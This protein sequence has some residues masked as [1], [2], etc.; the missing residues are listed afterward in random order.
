[1]EVCSVVCPKFSPY[2]KESVH[3]LNGLACC[4][5]V[6]AASSPAAG[7]TCKQGAALTSLARSRLR[8]AFSRTLRLQKHLLS[9]G[10]KT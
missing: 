5:R 10:S 9:D 2:G 4:T 6:A 7:A 1:M 3:A 8:Q